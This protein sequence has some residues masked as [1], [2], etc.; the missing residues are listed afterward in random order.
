MRV[1]IYGGTF[2]PIH[3]A[4]L[5]VASEAAESLS[6]DRVL[7]VTSGNPPHKPIGATTPFEHRHR[8][9]ELACAADPRFEPSRLEEGAEKSYSIE[10]ILRVQ[11]TLPAG[12]ALFFLIGAD[13]FAEIGTWHRSAEV[14]R[15][16]DF[17][18]VSRPGYE[19]PVPEGARLH[20]LESV[21]LDVSS[22]AIRRRCVA[23]K[24]EAL[25]EVLPALVLEY[26]RQHRL[27]QSA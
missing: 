15:A 25:A 8:M 11:K 7:F 27:Y 23:G 13:A 21:A 2:D 18:V 22:S 3:K 4:H 12:S 24:W 19:Y 6:L 20:K 1:A 14:L 16:V 26:V 9:V 5:R 10:T 17:V